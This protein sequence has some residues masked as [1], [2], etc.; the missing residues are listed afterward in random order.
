MEE[1]MP[2]NQ[3]QDEWLDLPAVAGNPDARG[4]GVVVRT[5]GATKEYSDNIPYD[6]FV[7]EAE[8]EQYDVYSWVPHSVASQQQVKAASCAHLLCAG[9]CPPGCVCDRKKGRC[10]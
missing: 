1:T 10:K 6:K 8:A 4:T 2:D 7:E 9:K 5:P 3:T